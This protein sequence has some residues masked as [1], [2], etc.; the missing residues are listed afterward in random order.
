MRSQHILYYLLF[1]C[2]PLTLHGQ[3]VERHDYFFGKIKNLSQRNIYDAHILNKSAFT[4]TISNEKGEFRIIAREGDTLVVSCIGY[5]VKQYVVT[6]EMMEFRENLFYL[7]TK[8]Y[9]LN[10]VILTSHRLTGIIAVDIQLITLP[11][12]RVLRTIPGIPSSQ[13]IG[14]PT[15]NTPAIYNTVDFF[16]SIFSDNAEQLRKVDKIRSQRNFAEALNQKYDRE[17]IA[18]LLNI[19]IDDVDEIIKVCNL[20]PEVVARLSDLVVLQIIKDCYKKYS[21]SE[22]GTSI[23]IIEVEDKK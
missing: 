4:G 7:V 2:I 14:P 5:H 20:D 10:E 22:L 17:L 11:E 9:V 23:P 1:I 6:K 19:S 3:D 15:R 8:N 16:Y 13:D 18:S 21:N 12:R